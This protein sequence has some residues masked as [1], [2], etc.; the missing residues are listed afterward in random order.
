MQQK[1]G[2][3]DSDPSFSSEDLGIDNEED[4]KFV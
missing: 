1:F 3:S 2:V 4:L